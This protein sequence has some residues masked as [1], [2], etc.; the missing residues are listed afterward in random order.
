MAGL[1]LVRPDV[2]EAE[3]EAAARVVRSGW[4]TQGAEVEA[5]EAEFAAAVG[6]P[7]AVAVSNC[8]VALQLALAAVGV[9]RGRRGHGE[10]QLHCY[11]ER[12]RRRGRTSRLRG[13]RGRHARPRP[14]PARG[15]A[16]AAHARRAVRAPARLSLRPGARPRDRRLPWPARGRGRGLCARQRDR[17]ARRLGAHRSATRV[18]GLLLAPPPE[19][20][21]DGRRGD[22]HHPGRRV[23][24]RFRLQRQHAMS[25]P[26]T[27]RHQSKSVV[28]EEY[29]EPAFNYRLTD[30]QAAVGRPQIARLDA[31]VAERRRLAAVYHH[32]LAGN[33][34]LAPPRERTGSRTNWQSYPA[35]LKRVRP[36]RRP[37]CSS[38]ST[39][40]RVQARRQQRA[41]GA[42]VPLE[43]RLGLRPAGCTLG[44]PRERADASPRASGSGTRPCCC[45]STTA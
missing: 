28:F 3:A 32:A 31:I 4:L 15:G 38:C 7:H 39:R 16:H 26:D 33:A 19:G 17:V 9:R 14:G 37:C 36:D 8:T 45:R 1:P 30:L 23:A 43:G 22:P 10:P 27:I 11:G 29:L 42:R 35:R 12:G 13:C 40:D 41:P 34:V 25:I 2:G 5:F 24:R 6:A 20:R 21:H 44:A 18:G